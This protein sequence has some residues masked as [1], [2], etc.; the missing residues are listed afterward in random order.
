MITAIR[1]LFR[2]LLRSTRLGKQFSAFR[3]LQPYLEKIGWLNSFELRL[4]VDQ[5]GDAL[6]WLTYPA[7]SFLHERV[8]PDMAV[9]EYGSG[10]STL[11]WSQRVSR[12]VSYEH[13]L[14]WYSLLQGRFPS[15]VEYRH[16]R[17]VYGGEYSKKILDYTDRFEVIVIDGRDRVS[18][19]KNSLGALRENG[20]ILWDNSDREKYREGYSFLKQNGFRRLDFEGFGPAAT[21]SWCTAVFY[22]EK[23][24][25][26]I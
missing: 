14:E 10:N 24:C 25:L 17:L 23:N 3:E 12:L 5:N 18:C 11:W 22:R 7:I 15:N 1:N 4:P 21:K 13:D 26:G 9:F 19:V 16:C 2:K 20:V 8:Q 6:P